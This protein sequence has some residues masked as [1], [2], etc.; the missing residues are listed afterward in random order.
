MTEQFDDVSIQ[1]KTNVH[2]D[3]KS[4]S[5]VIEYSDGTKKTIGV[6]L[7]TDQPLKFKTYVLELIE[8]IS[9]ECEVWIGIEEEYLFLKS[10]E[11]FEVPANSQFKIRTNS[12]LDYTCHLIKEL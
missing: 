8:I 2:F 5:R 9:G 3:G 4:I 7:P 10:G 12:V 1:K 11:S 6:I